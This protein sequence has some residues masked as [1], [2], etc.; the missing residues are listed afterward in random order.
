MRQMTEAEHDAFIEE[1]AWK[2]NKERDKILKGL[3]GL[4]V[5][6]LLTCGNCVG[7]G[8]TATYRKRMAAYAGRSDLPGKPYLF[9]TQK[10]E[11][12]RGN[13][14]IEAFSASANSI[15]AN[16]LDLENN[17]VDGNF[18]IRDYVPGNEDYFKLERALSISR[19]NQAAKRIAGMP[20]GQD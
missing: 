1:Q 13:T 18:S 6:T 19:A 5:G 9:V 20:T 15:H 3:G 16:N 10:T 4:A 8:F 7:S 11:E 17:H 12:A 2:E 14:R